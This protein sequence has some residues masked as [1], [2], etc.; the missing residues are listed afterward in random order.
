MYKMSLE[1][2]VP[3]AKKLPRTNEITSKDTEATSKGSH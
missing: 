3:E 2:L 1:Y